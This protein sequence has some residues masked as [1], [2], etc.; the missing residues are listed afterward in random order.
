MNRTNTHQSNS[1]VRDKYATINCVALAKLEH[2]RTSWRGTPPRLAILAM[3]LCLGCINVTA[4]VAT[5]LQS[6]MSE[7]PDGKKT[8]GARTITVQSNADSGP[9]SLRAI[10]ATA[11]GGDT[12]NVAAS[13]NIILTSGELVVTKDLTIRGPGANGPTIDGGGKSRVFRVIAGVT[14]TIDGLVITNGRASTAPTDFPANLG[15]GIY[16]DHANLTVSNCVLRANSAPFGGAILSDG[17]TS[18]ANLTIIKCLFSNNSATQGG[19]IYNDGEQSGS[20]NLQIT[21]CTFTGNSAGLVGGAILNDG[22]NGSAVL[23][24]TT[25]TIT[26]SI[27]GCD[28]G[29]FLKGGS[30]IYNDGGFSGT[31]IAT[32]TKSTITG[33]GASAC[34][35]FS[36]YGGGIISVGYFGRAA[37][38][39]TDSTL[40][41]NRAEYGGGIF[42]W[43]YGG[44]AELSVINSTLG[45]ANQS[46]NAGGAVYHDYFGFESTPQITNST[47]SG[48]SSPG[49]AGIYATG[50]STLS[51]NNDTISDNTGIGV[52]NHG[53]LNVANCIFRAAVSGQ[54]LQGVPITS[55]GFNLSSDAAGGLLNGL[56]D[57]LNRDPLLGPLQNNGGPT[58]TQALLPNSPAINSGSPNFTP[59]ALVPPLFADQRGKPRVANGRID[60]GA[61]ESSFGQ[62]INP[63]KVKVT[64]IGLE[65]GGSYSDVGFVFGGAGSNDIILPAPFE[66]FKSRDGGENWSPVD[67]L[68]RD[69]FTVSATLRQDPKNPQVLL[70]ISEFQLHRSTDFGTTWTLLS[71]DPDDC[72]FSPAASNVILALET[73]FDGAEPLWRSENA[74]QT[75]VRQ[76]NTGLPVAITDPQTFEPI[77]EPIYFNI[78]TTPADPNVVYVLLNDRVGYYPVGIY[79]SSNGGRSFQPLA[80]SPPNVFQLFVHPT[81]PNVLFVNSRSDASSLQTFRSLDG[82]NTF[83]PLPNGSPPGGMVVFDPHNPLVIYVANQ[84]LFRSADL[85]NSFQAL[86]LTS[87]QLGNNGGVTAASVDP[88]NPKVLFVN[89]TRGNFK[90]VDGGKSFKSISRGWRATLINDLAFDNS[91]QPSLYIAQKDGLG[92]VK[93][94]NRGKDYAQLAYPVNDPT[95]GGFR[96]QTLAI[97]PTN[98]NVIF[99]GTLGGLFRTTDGGKSWKQSSI[100]AGPQEFRRRQSKVVIDPV[101]ASKVYF[102]TNDD[103]ADLPFGG[104]YRSNDGGSTFVRTFAERLS[105][106]AI[107]PLNRGVFYASVEPVESGKPSFYKSLD[108]GL[109]FSGTSGSSNGQPVPG[110]LQEGAEHILVDPVSPNNVYVCSSRRGVIEENFTGVEHYFARSTDGGATFNAADA[111]LP[112]VFDMAFDPQNPARLFAYTQGGL[113]V[114]DDR[115]TSW[116]LVEGDKTLKAAGA[117]TLMAINPRQPNL[118]YLAGNSSVLEVEIGP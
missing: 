110:T 54:S 118:I 68:N 107:D 117:N 24:I 62:N 93:T 51:L 61:Y 13:K 42:N 44:K 85:G 116:R 45:P 59:Y 95:E 89:T 46:D 56:G 96:I 38:S 50:N 53:R 29:D 94:A 4:Q 67:L 21:N 109:S 17:E 25:S 19:A 9:A 86:G 27:A 26:S 102:V 31:A 91:R 23:S 104:F 35:D 1:T 71:F 18:S 81:N 74:G 2:A 99:G 20:A 106:L 113:F 6:S 114:T 14:A 12:I 39:V 43:A 49:G 22:E 100:D 97:S 80:G 76:A 52:L 111:A 87:A 16:S 63:P 15:G 33:N 48:N 105:T 40:S 65:A 72:A 8:P 73:S 78:I 79:K 70:A 98:P 37:L 84:Q 112:G 83:T 34:G 55:G 57:I 108:R 101:D 103:F 3:T 36:R 69:G 5:P 64:D 58:M 32:V 75:F 115:G 60:I 7:H 77:A 82:G 47:I 10:L 11:S 66:L 88:H 92:V 41:R 90:S 30:A 28:T